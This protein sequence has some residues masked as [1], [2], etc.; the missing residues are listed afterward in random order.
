MNLTKADLRQFI[1][2]EVGNLQ[3]KTRNIEDDQNHDIK[4]KEALQI[5]VRQEVEKCNGKYSLPEDT[6][7][8]MMRSKA[9]SMQWLIWNFNLGYSDAP[10]HNNLHSSAQ[11][12]EEFVSFRPSNLV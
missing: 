7:T 3:I 5:F 4:M 8:L 2:E 1:I 11:K 12:R 10:R 6:Y 9:C